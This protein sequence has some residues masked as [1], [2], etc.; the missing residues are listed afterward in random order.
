MCVIM[1]LKSNLGEKA[2]KHSVKSARK[3]RLEG[4][5]KC[6]KLVSKRSQHYLFKQSTTANIIP[7]CSALRVRL[8]LFKYIVLT[9]GGAHVLA[10]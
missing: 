3:A 6:Q 9:I 4:A 7:R 2:M 10:L 1:F 5:K 8:V